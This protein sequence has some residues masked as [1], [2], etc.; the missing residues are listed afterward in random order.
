MKIYIRAMSDK[1]EVI[2]RRISDPSDKIIEHIVKLLL[3]PDSQYC[4][5]WKQEIYSFLN[6]IPTLKN[7]GKYPKADWIYRA[8]T[9]YNDQIDVIVSDVKEEYSSLHAK[10]I[11]IQ[12]ITYSIEE[13]QK[14]LAN[15]LSSK[16]RVK[17]QEVYQ[18]LDNFA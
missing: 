17:S 4:N 18:A 7:N 10:D 8:L 6:R 14:W 3:Y 5:H 12:E 9:I 1:K 13:Y 15:E 16:G 11:S 2:Y